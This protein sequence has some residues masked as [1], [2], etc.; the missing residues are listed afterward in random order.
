MLD[1]PI[2]RV[3]YVRFFVLFRRSPINVVHI[4]FMR[5]N[6]EIGLHINICASCIPRIVSNNAPCDMRS[7]IVVKSLN[8]HG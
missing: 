2:H 3:T 8:K 7:K 1:E 5:T 4:S 6:S